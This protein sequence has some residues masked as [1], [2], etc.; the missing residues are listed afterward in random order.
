MKE[1]RR[2][3]EEAARANAEDIASLMH[4]MA[5]RNA[6][7]E[8]GITQTAKELLTLRHEHRLKDRWMVEHLEDI[9]NAAKTKDKRV[10]LVQRSAIDEVKLHSA[11]VEKRT[12]DII[13]KLRTQT[14]QGQEQLKIVREQHDALQRIFREKVN[15]LQDQIDRVAGK[16]KDMEMRRTLEGEG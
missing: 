4:S 9:K 15:R 16:Y 1:E 8:R 6:K 7:A 12:D 13:A 10:A 5:E 2:Q 11:Q 14:M 3:G